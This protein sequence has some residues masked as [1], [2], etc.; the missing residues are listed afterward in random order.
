MPFYDIIPLWVLL[1]NVLVYLFFSLKGLP[2]YPY[3]F[4]SSWCSG[5]WGLA[6]PGHSAPPSKRHSCRCT[7]ICKPANLESVPAN[8]L[9]YSALIG[10]TTLTVP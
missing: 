6:D 1:S 10:R 7:P 5:I 4:S 9:L 3:C 2:G 8:C